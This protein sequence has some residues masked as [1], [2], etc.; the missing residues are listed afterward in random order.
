MNYFL[1]INTYLMRASKGKINYSRE[2]QLNAPRVKTALEILKKRTN[3]IMYCREKV[4]EVA[5]FRDY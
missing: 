3:L 4:F 1:A 2:R 5:S